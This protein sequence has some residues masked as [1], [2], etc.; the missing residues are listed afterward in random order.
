[1]HRPR[2]VEVKHSSCSTAELRPHWM[3]PAGLEPATW[4]S[5]VVPPAFA[6]EASNLSQKLARQGWQDIAADR[7]LAW[8]H[9]WDS[10]PRRSRCSPAC[11]RAQTFTAL[12][13]T[14]KK[15]ACGDKNSRGHGMWKTCSPI[16][17]RHTQAP[18][19]TCTFSFAAKLV[20]EVKGV[21]RTTKIT[22]Q[23]AGWIPIAHTRQLYL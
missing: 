5:T 23:R 9:G 10:N 16:G 14:F 17:I 12:F 18:V 6:A 3:R 22:R 15:P 19:G 1:M 4:K 21:P 11:I 7:P 13:M 8:L 20:K 2:R